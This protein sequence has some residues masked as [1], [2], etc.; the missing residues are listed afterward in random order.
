[1]ANVLVENQSLQ[2]I[3]DAIRSKNGSSDTYKPS[4]MAGA[5]SAISTGSTIN[6]QDITVHPSSSDQTVSADSGYTG[7]GDV[8]VKA[9]TVENLSAANIVSGVTVK[10]GDADDDDRIASVT[11]TASTGGGDVGKLADGSI[12]TFTDNT[13]T[14]LQDYCF[15]SCTSLTSVTAESVTSIGVSSFDGCSALTS[16]M[17]HK[18]STIRSSAQY[19]FRQCKF[20][21]VAL[22]AL[23]TVEANTFSGCTSMQVCDVKGSTIRASAFT[24]CSAL[25]TLIIRSTSVSALANVNAFS[26]TP[27]ASGG[28][29]GTIYIPKSL[30]DHLGDNTSYDYKKASNWTTVDGYG[31]ITW[32]K[33]E[34]SHYETYYGD[35]TAIPTT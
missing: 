7:L 21:K 23:S 19:A 32:A 16:L 8:T 6:N 35:E 9:V 18:I 17:A 33:I 2:D 11:G 22:P 28:A 25:N 34:G 12:T 26:N 3:A 24:G 13:I 15:R 14:R 31:T 10:V 29:G 1:M 5:I 20:A 30:Y 4:E 27:F